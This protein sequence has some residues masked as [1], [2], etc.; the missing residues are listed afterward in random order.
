MK[1]SILYVRER[2]LR[3]KAV[4]NWKDITLARERQAVFQR[5]QN[6]SITDVDQDF[7][8]KQRTELYLISF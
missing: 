7:E 1:I 6:L 4:A 5:K 3:L 2:I 8:F